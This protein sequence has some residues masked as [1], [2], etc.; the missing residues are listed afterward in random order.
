MLTSILGALF[1]L[2]VC[3]FI[4]ELGHFIAAIISKVKVV[5][6]SIGFGKR[7]FGFKKN[8]CEYQIAI[9]PFGGYVK[10]AGDSVQ[11]TTGSP[12]E[13]Y[14]KPVSTR[15]FIALSGVFMNLFLGWLLFFIIF[16]TG[17]PSIPP[18]V[19]EVIKGSPAFTKGITRGDEIV[20]IGKTDIT[21]W[22]DVVKK[23]AINP[24]K[25]YT[26][27]IVRNG[28]TIKKD[29][30]VE[31]RNGG[32]GYIGIVPYLQPK[33]G[34]FL[35]GFPGEK[36]GLIQGDVI[37]EINGKPIVSW[38]NVVDIIHKNPGVPCNLKVERDNKII[39]ISLI[40]KPQTI[41]TQTIGM[42]GIEPSFYITKRYNPI[43]AN[44]KAFFEVYDLIVLNILGIY[45]MI[46]GE[47]SPKMISGPIGILQIASKTAHQGFVHLLKFT[48]LIS[49]CLVIINLLPIPITDGGL[50]LFFLIEGI[51]KKPFS[52]GFY[53]RAGQIGFGI[54]ILIFF[55]V[56]MN[57]ITR[58]FEGM[59]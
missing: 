38:E 15:I 47:I 6:F 3:I 18:I 16:T 22:E 45:K 40:P 4:H 26:F 46:K 44:N 20:R 56:S 5:K 59:K 27:E 19:G 13:F 25:R 36:S 11:E 1:V 48:A 55:L 43:K 10:L 50:V 39:K 21:G 12:W 9:I 58:L 32:M 8:D 51:R 53:E 30:L 34:G 41:G 49:V 14:S 17:A 37:K 57:D 31:S 7:L 52:Q 23:I 42:I 54:I 29:I 28:K 24:N 33:I 2:S 35:K